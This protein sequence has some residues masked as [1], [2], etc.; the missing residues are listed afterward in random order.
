MAGSVRYLLTTLDPQPNGQPISYPVAELPFAGVTFSICPNTSGPFSATLSIEDR[1]VAATNWINATNPGKCFF[2]VEIDGQYVY[3][4]P[5]LD[6]VYNGAEQTVTITGSDFYSYWARR[7]QAADYTAHIQSYVGATSQTYAWA[8]KTAAIANPGAPTPMIAWQL[9]SDAAAVPGSLPNLSVP[10]HGQGVGLKSDPD[11]WVSSYGGANY[12]TFSGPLSQQ[13]TIDAL[14]QQFI[15]MGYQVGVDVVTS[16]SKDSNGN[17]QAQVWV[18]W[19]RWGDTAVEQGA[20]ISSDGITISEQGNMKVLDLSTVLDLEWSEDASSQ[21]ISIVEMTGASGAVSAPKPAA[22]A[23]AVAHHYP[24]TEQAI[25]HTS[26]SPT[27]LSAAVLATLLAGDRDLYTYPQIAP[28]VTLP[29]FS[30]G[31]GWAL[32]ELP[33][34]NDIGIFNPYE[35][36][37]IGGLTSLPFPTWNNSL[38]WMRLV[39]ADVTIADE[40]VSTMQLTL[41]PPPG[42]PSPPGYE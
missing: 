7:L 37:G 33:M 32:T 10:V 40:G 35:R 27:T 12:I 30:S 9:L 5:I 22:D 38:G 2:W 3:G 16:V 18:C 28:V 15:G 41:N 8:A 25:S 1:Q 42:S 26:T 34:G 31:T 20:T 6:R 17:P 14:L 19:P 29:V 24:L 39:R 23:G 11:Y 13:Q 21:A 4:G 36:Q